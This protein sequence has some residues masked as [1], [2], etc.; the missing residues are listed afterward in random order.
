[1]LLLE[2]LCC[3]TAPIPI[4]ARVDETYL[5]GVWVNRKSECEAFDLAARELWSRGFIV[6]RVRGIS[7]WKQKSQVSS[8]VLDELWEQAELTGI[9]VLV[10]ETSVRLSGRTIRRNSTERNGKLDNGGEH[11]KLRE[12]AVSS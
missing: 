6:L 12:S 9:S 3:K 2:F 1:M 5:V 10:A 4:R 11:S 8:K 7:R